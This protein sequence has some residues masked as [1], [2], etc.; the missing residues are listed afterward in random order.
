[1]KDRLIDTNILVYA[2]DASEGYKHRAARELLKSVWEEGG[3]I[4]CLQNLM[5]FFVV[6][7]RKVENPIS[8][9]VAKTIIE[10][11]L[12]SKNWKIIDRDTDTLLKAIDI[13][14]EYRIHLW[15]A[16]I[17]ACMKENDVLEIV[18]ENRNDFERI[19][20]IKVTIPF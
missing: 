4:V 1:M 17:V 20:E 15:D 18:T 14:F 19:P 12:K 5:E 11:I 3:G 8:I 9:I 16:L 7:T 13:T 2:Y 10:D 6:I